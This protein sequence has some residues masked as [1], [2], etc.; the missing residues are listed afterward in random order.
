MSFF[1]IKL[2][3]VMQILDCAIKIWNMMVIH[4]ENKRKIP[5]KTQTTNLPPQ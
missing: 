5:I 2:A 1:P 4:L 3:V